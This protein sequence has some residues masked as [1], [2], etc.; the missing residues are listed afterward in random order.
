MK[1]KVVV[2][3]IR[4]VAYVNSSSDRTHLSTLGCIGGL[5][6]LVNQMISWFE[7]CPHCSNN[8]SW[9]WKCFLVKVGVGDLNL[10]TL[11]KVSSGR[12]IL[13]WSVQKEHNISWQA[14]NWQLKRQM[15]LILYID[16]LIIFLWLFCCCYR[17]GLLWWGRISSLHSIFGESNTNWWQKMET[18]CI[19]RL[20]SSYNGSKNHRALISKSDPCSLHAL[21][22]FTYPPTARCCLF[23]PSEASF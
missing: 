7:N 13:F 21:S 22:Y 2:L 8:V 19:W 4:R 5:D 11:W 3:K 17:K 9:T 15:S 18:A 6:P 1:E 23:W 16:S 14:G 20:W 12:E 10:C